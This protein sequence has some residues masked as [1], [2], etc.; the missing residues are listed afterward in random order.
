M[1]SIVVDQKY[2][3]VPVGKKPTAEVNQDLP[4]PILA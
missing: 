3:T 1:T 4:F 2:K